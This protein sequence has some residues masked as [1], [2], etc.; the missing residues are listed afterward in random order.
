M[1][2][3]LEL[4]EVIAETF[5]KKGNI[6]F[7][8]FVTCI[9][10]KAN[11][12]LLLFCYLHMAIPI[13][14]KKLSIYRKKNTSL[15]N[16]SINSSGSEKH[17]NDSP[18]SANIG[19]SPNSVNADKKLY[20]SPSL[21]SPLTEYIKHKLKASSNK[22][23]KTTILSD[24]SKKSKKIN[25]SSSNIIPSLVIEKN[26]LESPDTPIRKSLRTLGVVD[27]DLKANIKEKMNS[28]SNKSLSFNEVKASSFNEA[29]LNI[30]KSEMHN[31]EDFKKNSKELTGLVKTNNTIV[32]I[33][34]EF[35]KSSEDLQVDEDDIF[36]Q[37]ALQMEKD[38]QAL[39]DQDKDLKDSIKFEGEL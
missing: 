26:D 22:P 16:L 21:F 30:I 34:E 3:L 14:D 1:E 27:F 17:V 5:K 18:K 38:R 35:G 15:K 32:E 13:L 39:L 20:I 11:I 23:V 28:H 24:L 2:S 37:Q 29:K 19:N 8:E 12:F 6:S 9:E 36:A 4:D 31:W 25:N 33:P 7:A 10:H